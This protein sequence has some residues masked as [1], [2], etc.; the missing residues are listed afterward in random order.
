MT[1]QEQVSWLAIV[2]VLLAGAALALAGSSQSVFVFGLPVFGLS[3]ALAIGMQWLAFVPAYLRQTERFYDLTGGLTYLATLSLAWWVGGRDDTRSMVVFAL[4]AIWAIRLASFLFLRIH[5]AGKDSRFDEIKPSLPRFLMAWTLQGLW[6][7]LTA[8]AAYA[9]LADP[10]KV[11]PDIY[12]WVGA[13]VWLVGFA[14]EVIAD[15]QKS[16]FRADPA[17]RGRFI[18]NG[19][20]AVSRHPNYLGEII[21]WVGIL[22]IAIPVLQSWQ[23]VVVL[24]PI[25]VWLLLT[26]VSGV[27]MLEAKADKTWGGQTDYEEY[28]RSTPILWPRIGR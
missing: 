13:G 6:V 3:V 23:W 5:H 12:L 9:I 11:A 22:I 10:A 24:S 7:S 19:L 8:S 26:K 18:G 25:F 4:C 15:A 27:P 17:N 2:I 1:K 14:I 16:A 28:K 20:W 21:L